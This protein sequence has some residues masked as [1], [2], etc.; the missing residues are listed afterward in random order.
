MHVVLCCVKTGSEALWFNPRQS[1]KK[2]TLVE[3][4]FSV[5]VI[6]LSQKHNCTKYTKTSVSDMCII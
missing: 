2:L 5:S 6:L 1:G 4:D 3:V